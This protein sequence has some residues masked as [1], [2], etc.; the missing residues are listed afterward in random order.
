MWPEC[1]RPLAGS[2]SGSLR[3]LFGDP[4]G[5]RFLLG[6]GVVIE[7]E[8]LAVRLAAI[9]CLEGKPR[10]ADPRH[11]RQETVMVD[12]IPDLD[13]VADGRRFAGLSGCCSEQPAAKR[14]A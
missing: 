2:A 7:N 1:R 10:F 13:S 5:F 14:S 8:G 12:V 9:Q 4:A 6:H 3:S 11:D